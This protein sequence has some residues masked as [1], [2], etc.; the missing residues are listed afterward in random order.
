[1]STGLVP[2]SCR[3]T[4]PAADALG[5]GQTMVA[6]AFLGGVL[7]FVLLLVPGVRDPER[8]SPPAQAPPPSGER[9]EDLVGL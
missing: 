1:M 6:G 3:L 5:A 8:G 2:I 9:G 4:G 7:T